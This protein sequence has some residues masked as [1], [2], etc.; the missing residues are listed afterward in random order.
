MAEFIDPFK[1]L[2]FD[3]KLNDRELLRALRQ[4]SCSRTRSSSSL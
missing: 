4:S 3:G 2:D 1:V